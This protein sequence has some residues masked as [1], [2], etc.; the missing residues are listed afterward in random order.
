MEKKEG[1]GEYA[2]D[3][4]K[5]DQEVGGQIER[6]RGRE[7]AVCAVVSSSLSFSNG[8]GRERVRDSAPF[9]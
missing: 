1:E 2:G 3:R 6:E 7:W 9:V 4:G 8:K 5:E